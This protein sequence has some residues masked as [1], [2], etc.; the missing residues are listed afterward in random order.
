M[1]PTPRHARPA[2]EDGGEFQDNRSVARERRED[3]VEQGDGSPQFPPRWGEHHDV[4]HVPDDPHLLDLGGTYGN[5]NLGDPIQ[6]DELRIE[7]DQG[8][9]EIIVYNRA[10]LLFMTDSETVSGFTRRAAGSMRPEDAAA[11][12]TLV[13]LVTLLQQQ[14]VRS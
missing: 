5:P 9:V 13:Q 11:T 14:P 8:D 3:T 1:Q 6:Y 10:I 4:V 7:H 12:E 2:L